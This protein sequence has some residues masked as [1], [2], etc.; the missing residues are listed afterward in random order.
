MFDFVFLMITRV[1]RV[2]K[3]GTLLVCVNNRPNVKYIRITH[4]SQTFV[5]S[6]DEKTNGVALKTVQGSF[7]SLVFELLSNLDGGLFEKR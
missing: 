4:A 5:N 6:S 1:L 2:I 3:T 7:H